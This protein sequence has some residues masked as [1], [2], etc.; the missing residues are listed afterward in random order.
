MVVYVFG[1]TFLL[2]QLDAQNKKETKDENAVEG[3]RLI[4]LRITSSFNITIG[5]EIDWYFNGDGEL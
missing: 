2:L 3:L 1:F 5:P 4:L